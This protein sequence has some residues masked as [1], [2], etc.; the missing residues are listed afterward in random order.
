[1][2]KPAFRV[3][4]SAGTISALLT[5]LSVVTALAGDGQNPLPK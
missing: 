5:L 1:M 4:L 3:F 2:R